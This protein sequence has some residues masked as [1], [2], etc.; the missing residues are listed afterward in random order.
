MGYPKVPSRGVAAKLAWVALRD[1]NNV[2]IHVLHVDGKP[3]YR[4][5][6][7][8]ARSWCVDYLTWDADD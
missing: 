7:Y 6:P 1:H 5:A 2:G 8:K 4:V 3:V